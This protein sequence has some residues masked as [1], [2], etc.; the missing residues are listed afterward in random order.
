MFYPGKMPFYPEENRG[1]NGAFPSIRLKNI[2]RGQQDALIMDM[3]EKKAGRDQVVAIINKVV[4]RA[5]SEVNMD[6]PVPWSESGDD[7]DRARLE[8]LKLL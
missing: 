3:A 6:E 8:L 7:Y 5:L 4:P 1:V 2:R